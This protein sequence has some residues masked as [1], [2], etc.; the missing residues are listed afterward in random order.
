MFTRPLLLLGAAIEVGGHPQY[1]SQL[2]NGHNSYFTTKIPGDGA[3][4]HDGDKGGAH[5]N[6]FGKEYPGGDDGWRDWSWSSGGDLFQGQGGA[7]PPVKREVRLA[8]ACHAE[9]VQRVRLNR[10]DD[11]DDDHHHHKGPVW[12]V[13]F[14][15]K[16]ADKDGQY[17]GWE[18]G[19][20]CCTW[21]TGRTPANS[22]DISHPGMATEKT[23]R[24]PCMSNRN[25]CGRAPPIPPP[26]PPPPAP[27][28]PSPP[29]PSP[30]GPPETWLQL[31]S[32]DCDA[33]D[34]I[35]TCTGSTIAACE[36]ECDALESHSSGCDGFNW[37]HKHFK[38]KGCYSRKRP[39][40]GLTLYVR[41][42]GPQPAPAPPPPAPPSPSP[43]PPIPQ[44]C[45]KA[46]NFVCHKAKSQGEAQCLLCAGEHS[47]TLK[48]EHCTETDF[49]TFCGAKPATASAARVFVQGRNAR[50]ILAASDGW[51]VTDSP[52]D[53]DL[54]WL[55][56][57]CYLGTYE[58]APPQQA[59]NM[60]PWDLPLVDKARLAA[61]LKR[62]AP[63][64]AT[65]VPTTIRLGDDEEW[66][67]FS[68]ELQACAPKKSC[69]PWILKRTDLSNG[70]G[71]Q[72]I[73]DVAA[74]AEGGARE[75]LLDKRL[76][77]IL[78]RYVDEPLLLG[79]RKSELR[80]YWLIA[81]LDPLVVLFNEG[82]VR[83][84]AAPY[85]RADYDNDLVHITNT[86]RQLAH[87]SLNASQTENHGANLKLKWTHE[88]LRDDLAARG[89]GAD[90]WE[91]LQGRLRQI[92]MRS[93]NATRP[94]L[95]ERVGETA[96]T[97]QLLGADFIVDEQLR[98]WLTEVQV[99]PG[100]SHD[101]PVKAALIPGLV[102]DAAAIGLAAARATALEDPQARA[103]AMA[104]LGEGTAF[105]TLANEAAR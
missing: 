78:Q 29:G 90:A 52:Q 39:F 75:R 19:D 99:G 67:D 3:I 98:P 40:D 38:S 64:F 94:A 2:P 74:W 76:P 24:P 28:S 49:K 92:I 77:Y 7:P 66:G 36:K 1:L 44:A 61:H 95:S 82:T 20:P 63:D 103:A 51:A 17:N 81:S 53:A 46:L 22:T 10:A 87:K 43:G 32:T 80:T 9:D 88:Q 91:T 50:A 85:Q 96:G 5:L 30:P 47:T 93:V 102:R 68:A 42:T 86:R 33:S 57:R 69:G 70:E 18:L 60:L 71:A 21:K 62:S 25:I 27:P 45:Q 101:E 79:G 16:D 41:Q 54:I 89:Y 59:L 97:F 4:G 56:N 13:K 48:H 65:F 73:P 83:L 14:C 23:H 26:G 8:Q 100:L 84:N 105:V 72:I 58:P 15:C 11:D 34:N 37:P 35:G 55:I 31:N 12:D 6:S 104:R